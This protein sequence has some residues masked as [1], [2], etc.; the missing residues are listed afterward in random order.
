VGEE[1][2]DLDS[3]RWSSGGIKLAGSVAQKA[4]V[5]PTALL[6]VFLVGGAMVRLESDGTLLIR[7]KESLDMWALRGGG[8]GELKA[9]RLV[10]G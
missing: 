5:A 8:D 10:E 4:D 7:C 2:D 6:G 9:L 3:S 1:R